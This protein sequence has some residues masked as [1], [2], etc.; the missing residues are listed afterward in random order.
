LAEHAPT[1]VRT[2]Q[3]AVEI[4]VDEV[5]VLIDVSGRAAALKDEVVT[6][7]RTFDAVV[8]DVIDFAGFIRASCVTRAS[9]VVVDDI[10]AEI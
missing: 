9:A 6:A 10:V 4:Q 2:V 1:R 8:A 3:L 5:A 7:G